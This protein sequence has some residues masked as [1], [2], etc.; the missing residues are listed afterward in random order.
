MTL[1]DIIEPFTCVDFPD[2]IYQYKSYWISPV[3]DQIPL[4]TKSTD[5]GRRT[6]VRRN[7]PLRSQ[8]GGWERDCVVV[9]LSALAKE[10]IER[11][12]M[13]SL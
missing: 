13:L 4:Y 12:L 8:G 5:D 11:S 3:S 1:T 2:H 7:Y 9:G 10:G 6:L